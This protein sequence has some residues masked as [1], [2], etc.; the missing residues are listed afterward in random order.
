MAFQ[1][2]AALAAFLVTGGAPVD[3]PAV[4]PP[5]QQQVVVPLIEPAAL[6]TMM[7]AGAH[8]VLVDVRRPDE[9]AA[10]HIEGAMAMPLD[11]LAANY[12]SLP[13]NVTLVVYCRSGHRSAKAVQ[14]LLAHG[15]GQAVS[16]K[17]GITAFTAT[18]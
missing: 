2:G 13:K 17:G 14:F 15:Y 7:A 9:F 5:A 10:G 6:K 8:F 11:S 18:N 16:L 4:T 12:A 3:A 1:F